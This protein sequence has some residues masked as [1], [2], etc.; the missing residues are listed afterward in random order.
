[1]APIPSYINLSY[2]IPC[3]GCNG[4]LHIILLSTPVCKVFIP[5]SFFNQNIVRNSRFSILHSPNFSCFLITSSE[6]QSL[7]SMLYDA[8]R[9]ADSS[10]LVYAGPLGCNC[11]LKTL[12]R[13]WSSNFSMWRCSTWQASS[14]RGQASQKCL[15]QIHCDIC[16]QIERRG[17]G[18]TTRSGQLLP[19]QA[20][21][22]GRTGADF[23]SSIHRQTRRL[24]L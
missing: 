20:A 21:L 14:R 24:R 19:W 4:H 3:Y 9:N 8:P 7:Q 18:H 2:T 10:N 13:E 22:V 6:Q 15:Y 11:L 23:C 5:R 16:L 1:M 12:C 17:G